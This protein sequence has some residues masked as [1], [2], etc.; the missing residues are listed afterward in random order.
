MTAPPRVYC[1]F[2]AP[3]HTECVDIDLTASF[4]TVSHNI[5]ISKIA[6]SY[7]SPDIARWLLCYLRERQAATN[8][9][10]IKSSTG[11]SQGFLLS[12]SLFNYYIDDM[13]RPTPLVKRVYYADDITGVTTQYPTAGI[14]DQL[15][16]YQQSHSSSATHTSS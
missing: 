10:G 16:R 8:V 11:V 13:S 4:D 12:P 15:H 2:G 5:L 3:H 9:S 14:H 1:V 6:G 7:L